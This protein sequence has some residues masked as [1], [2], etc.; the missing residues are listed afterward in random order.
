M[1]RRCEYTH[2]E[3]TAK[4]GVYPVEA[5]CCKCGAINITT[6]PVESKHGYGFIEEPCHKCGYANGAYTF[7]PK[8]DEQIMKLKSL[9]YQWG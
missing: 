1:I 3:W 9:I 8:H 5:K 7:V 2:E 4:H 6:I